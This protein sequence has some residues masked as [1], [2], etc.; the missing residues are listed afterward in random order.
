ML[1]QSKF[2]CL[3]STII[4]WFSNVICHDTMYTITSTRNALWLVNK[5]N[6]NKTTCRCGY[7]VDKRKFLFL[8]ATYY[9]V[10]FVTTYWKLIRKK[11]AISIIPW[12]FWDHLTISKVCD[13]PL[14]VASDALPSV[15]TSLSRN[16]FIC[17]STSDS[18]IIWLKFL[19]HVDWTRHC[20]LPVAAVWIIS[21][22]CGK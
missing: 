16:H 21:D 9:C 2:S 6:Y 12:Y 1:R 15:K 10:L 14:T 5:V 18:D 4:F 7:S 3:S 11:E 19:P 8:I 17:T 13:R 22:D 20:S